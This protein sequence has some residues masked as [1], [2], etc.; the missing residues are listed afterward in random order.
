MVKVEDKEWHFLVFIKKL[1]VL[2]PKKPPKTT[3]SMHVSTEKGK[4]SNGTNY[5]TIL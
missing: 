5:Y 4:K 2:Y 1:L 3:I